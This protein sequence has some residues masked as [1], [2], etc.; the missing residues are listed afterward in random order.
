MT[1]GGTLDWTFSIFQLDTRLTG[2]FPNSKQR[3]K[4]QSEHFES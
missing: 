1:A 4:Q 3:S 2:V